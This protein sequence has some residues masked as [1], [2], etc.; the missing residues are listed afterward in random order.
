MSVTPRQLPNKT[1]SP[2]GGWRYRVPETGQ[3]FRGVSEY[4]LL[5]QLQSHY[6]ANQLVAPDDLAARIEQFV[7]AQ[8]P[9]YCTDA[10]GQTAPPRGGLFHD[11]TNIL[12]GTRTLLA[13]KLKGGA[14][15]EPA[16]SERRA[17]TCVGCPQNDEPQGCTSCNMPTLK[18]LVTELVG[19]RRTSVHDQLKACRV[20][21]CQLAA[22]VQLQIDVLWSNMPD[23]QKT[24]L[25]ETCWLV[26]EASSLPVT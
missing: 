25:P 8:E 23:D 10:H 6:K 22:K 15:V 4:Q 21:S 13:W 24:R 18:R 3:V 1:Y 20:C 9:D 2:P 11:F 16:L 14:L 19:D 5:D 12:R 17:R 7:C 26:Q